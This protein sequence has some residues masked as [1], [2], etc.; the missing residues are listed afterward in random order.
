MQD[1]TIIRQNNR[2]AAAARNTGASHAKSEFLAF[3]DA[4]DEWSP[5][6]LEKLLD[7]HNQYPGAGICTTAYK[8]GSRYANYQGIP[9]TPRHFIIPDYFLSATLGEF[10]VNASSFGV[11]KT[12]F[13]R[14]GGFP[15]GTWWG[16]DAYLFGVIA[17]DNPVAFCWDGEAIYHRENSGT[18]TRPNTEMEPIVSANL[19]GNRWFSE[20]MVKKELYRAASNLYVG[21]K[22]VATKILQN[23]RTQVFQSQVKV[24]TLIS[25]LPNPI[26]REILRVRFGFV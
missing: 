25:H 1:I 5:D 21:N 7:L 8:I 9:E 24:L 2:G 19:R 12:I 22:G 20:Y 16:E 11:S 14:Y 10:P 4:D 6:H 18:C 15:E 23:A 3:L 26:L 17:L 13:S